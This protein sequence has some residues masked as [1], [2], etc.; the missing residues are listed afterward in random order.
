MGELA[1]ESVRQGGRYAEGVMVSVPLDPYLS[2]KAL[3]AYADLSVRKLRDL[4]DDPVH[5][6]PFYRVGGKI[7]V[8]R[9]EFDA[10]MTQYRDREAADVDRIVND[11][12]GELRH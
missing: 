10:W 12:I 3:S 2:I 11:V 6:L 7:L 5:P 1:T 9:S 4:L 8:R